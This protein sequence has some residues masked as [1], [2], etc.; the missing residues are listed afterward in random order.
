MKRII[1]LLLIICA[2]LTASPAFAESYVEMLRAARSNDQIIEALY[3][4]AYYGN[5]SCFW[6]FVKY[7]NYTSGESEGSNAPLVRR[8]AAE[9]LGRSKDDRGVQ[10]LVER[11]GKE[12][13]DTVKISIVFGLSFHSV[14]EIVPVIKDALASQNTDLRYQAVL[15]AERSKSKETISD[16]K[17]IHASDKD[18]TM[19]MVSSFALYSFGEDRASNEKYLTA[20]LR[21]S[22]PLVRYRAADYIGRAG[23]DSAAPDVIKAIEIENKW[24]VKSELDRAMDRI[25]E[26]KKKKRDSEAAEGFKF[27]EKDS[28]PAEQT[29]SSASSV[30]AK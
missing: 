16:I 15:A 19:R 4:L 22:D 3:Q 13:N 23:I 20:G 9:A 10:Y 17:A 24:W 21:S 29:P 1:L 8:A 30:P 25:Y 2:A 27:L 11:Y 28:A 5:R 18:D 26:V 6:D 14:P 12:K 7:L